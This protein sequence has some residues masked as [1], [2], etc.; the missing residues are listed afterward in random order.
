MTQKKS[1]NRRVV[2]TAKKGL[3][4]LVNIFFVLI[5]VSFFI[6][7]SR[8]L[9]TCARRIFI[10]CKTDTVLHFVSENTAFYNR[11]VPYFL[12]SSAVFQ[13]LYF[14]TVLRLFR[15]GSSYKNK[16]EPEQFQIHLRCG[17]SDYFNHSVVRIFRI[18]QVQRHR[19][20]HG[21]VYSFKRQDNR[22]RWQIP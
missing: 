15:K 7:H 21:G 10:F 14:S 3:Q 8:A 11:D 19:N 5:F 17:E 20:R 12:R 22:T 4:T 2:A 1:S 16:N 13:N 18:V 6:C 9:R